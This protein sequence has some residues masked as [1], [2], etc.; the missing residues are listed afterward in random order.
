[1]I[2]DFFIFRRCKYDVLSVICLFEY[3]LHEIFLRED[4]TIGNKS[5]PAVKV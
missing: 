5:R 3:C 1:M 2:F 4:E